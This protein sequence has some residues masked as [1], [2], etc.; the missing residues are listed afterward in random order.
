MELSVILPAYYPRADELR[1]T[2]DALR[3]Q[4][5]PFSRWELVIVDNRSTP[6]VGAAVAVWHPQSKIVREEQ[7]GLVAARLAGFA[8]TTGGVIVV[9]DQDN[10]LAPDYLATALQIGA[11]HPWLGTWGG[12]IIPRYERPEL[13]PPASLHSLL[14][15]RS[16]ARDL[17]SNDIDHHDST[18]WGAGLCLRRKVAE[19]YAES[20]KA[21]PLKGSLDL[22]GDLR[23]SGGDT[24]ISYTA[25][26]M[27]LGKGVFRSLQLEH[28][29]PA[30]RCTAD[31]LCK[32]AEGRGYSDVL[33]HLVLKGSLPPE[34]RGP[35][36]ALRTIWQMRNLSPLERQ[37]QAARAAGRRRAHREL[38]R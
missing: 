31:F 10:V 7:P 14:T 1:S 2:L 33:H 34:A 29:V 27:G 6:P 11:G 12:V 4:T 17:W 25:C 20:L 18:P 21:N 16:A 22:R 26:A 15:L 28:L 9:V 36:A 23:L 30:S 38:S 35:V 5:L 37:V 3:A 32:N 24:D 8:Q 19:R 13:A